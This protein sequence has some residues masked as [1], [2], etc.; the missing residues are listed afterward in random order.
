[1]EG[2]QLYTMKLA[3]HYFRRQYAQNPEASK[4]QLLVLQASVAGYLDIPTSLQYSMS[5][6]G[7]RSAM[8]TLRWTEAQ[9]GI[10]VN[11]INP[12]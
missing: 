9:H 7:M 8:R 12:W 6:F 2:A 4:D 1:M 5:K 3:L 11:S 10:R